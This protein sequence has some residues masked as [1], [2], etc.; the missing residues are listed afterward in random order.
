MLTDFRYAF[1]QLRSTPMVTAAAIAC[2]SIGVW[3]TC[4]V[5]SVGRGIYRPDLGVPQGEQLVQMDEV[6][7]FE[8][9]YTGTRRVSR[10]VYDSLEQRKLFAAIG[11]YETS[12]T[13]LGSEDR[14]RRRIVLSSGMMRVLRVTVAFGR[15]FVPADD[16]GPQ[17]AIIS[18]ELWRSF[19][20]RDSTVIGRTLR[21]RD[22]K[23][24]MT[25]VGVMRPGFVFLTDMGRADIYITPG[26]TEKDWPSRRMLARLERDADLDEIATVAA[27]I[28]RRNVSA[29]RLAYTNYYRERWKQRRAPPELLRGGIDPRLE[30]YHREPLDKASN[31]IFILILACGFAVVAIAGAN[32][33]NLTLIRGDARR[34]EIAVR[35]ALGASRGRIVGQLVIETGIVAVVGI[36]AGFGMAALQWSFLDPNFEY[37]KLFGAPFSPASR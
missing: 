3:L 37:R 2:L 8:P 1:R 15:G 20:G 22:D 13:F 28:A 33:V 12:I 4:I 35:M 21:F 27:G 29:D 6:G 10:G 26:Q 5:S 11:Y 36:L 16:S 9:N 25:V 23:R 31:G 30:R 17:V 34:Q 32:V 14:F 7:L 18:H 19:F 24:L